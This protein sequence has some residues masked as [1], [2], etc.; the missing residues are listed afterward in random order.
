MLEPYLERCHAAWTAMPLGARVPTLPST[1][2]GKVN[3]RALTLAL[4][5]KRHREQHFYNHAE[6]TGLVNSIAEAQGLRGI[7]SRNQAETED[8]EIADR[9]ARVQKE[10]GDLARLL[11]EREA[12][13]ERQRREIAALREQLR[14]LE[15]TG[16]VVRTAA[17][18]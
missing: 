6:L 5:L 15:E 4:G 9:I 3:V 13:I 17:I 7:K 14:L 12:V 1:D 8:V 10:R 2:D 11:A 18:R 16:M